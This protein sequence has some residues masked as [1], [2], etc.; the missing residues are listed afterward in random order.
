MSAQVI[1]FGSELSSDA[2]EADDREAEATKCNHNIINGIHFETLYQLYFA[3][4]PTTA[5]I[6]MEEFLLECD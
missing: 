4:E 5:Q 1:E 2:V 3:P 6:V